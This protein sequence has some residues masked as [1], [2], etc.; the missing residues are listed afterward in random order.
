MFK[1]NDV[2]RFTSCNN[3]NSVIPFTIRTTW[4]TTGYSMILGWS[5]I[6]RPKKKSAIISITFFLEFFNHCIS[7]VEKCSDMC[8]VTSSKSIIIFSVCVDRHDNIIHWND[9][10]VKEWE[11]FQHCAMEGESINAVVFEFIKVV[12]KIHHTRRTLSS[13]KVIITRVCITKSSDDCTT[14]S[15][16]IVNKVRT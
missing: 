12:S 3:T 8:L 9:I 11:S 13:T 7:F 16:D 1:V 2:A 10:I 14:K 4:M 6:I 5:T 15:D